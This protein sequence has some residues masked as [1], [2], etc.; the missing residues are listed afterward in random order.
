[1]EKEIGKN[2]VKDEENKKDGE[3][4]KE[5]LKEH[6]HKILDQEIY[7]SK[8][9]EPT[10]IIWENRHFTK[11]DIFKRSVTSVVAICLMIFVCF[12]GV[13]SIKSRLVEEQS[14]FPPVDCN[15]IKM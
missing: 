12:N 4:K 6:E 11:I 13:V 1:M 9:T 10:N 15:M 7:L 8:A 2:K 5:K 14:N 3:E